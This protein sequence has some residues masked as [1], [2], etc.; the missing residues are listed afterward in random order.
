MKK[1]ILNILAF[2]FL[3][4]VL[5]MLAGC[6]E[7][8][9][10]IELERENVLTDPQKITYD[11]IKDTSPGNMQGNKNVPEDEEADGL[12]SVTVYVC[13]A[14]NC[15]GVYSLD[16]TPRVVDAICAAGGFSDRADPDYINQAMLLS[17]GQKVYI[18]TIEETA[19]PDNALYEKC[20]GLSGDMGKKEGGECKV[21]INTADASEL[22]T[23][24][25][26]GKAKA[27]LIIEYRTSC[28]RFDS[29]EDIMKING[30][31]EGMFNKIKDRICI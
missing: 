22:M 23:L 4:I 24:P 13:G 12:S 27:A 7:D 10:V 15:S 18:P 28:G 25:G 11:E 31:K 9:A 29:V 19:N 8:E 2:F 3:S 6:D 26:I 30:I 14:V 1:S 5:M 20:E 16:G 17:D 21:N